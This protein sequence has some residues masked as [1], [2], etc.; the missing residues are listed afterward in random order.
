MRLRKMLP[1][2][3]GRGCM[4]ICIARR[5]IWGTLLFGI[6]GRG[7]QLRRGIRVWSGRG[8]WGRCWGGEVVLPDGLAARGGHF[9]TCVPVVVRWR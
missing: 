5:G 3:M 7:E 8:L 2:R 1:G 6:D 9:V 4:L